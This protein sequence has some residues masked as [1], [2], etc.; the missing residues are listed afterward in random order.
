[1]NDSNESEDSYLKTGLKYAGM[2]LG[3]VV[4]TSVVA[5]N[6]IANS[7]TDLRIKKDSLLSNIQKQEIL[8]SNIKKQEM[9]KKS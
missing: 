9:F 5:T 6:A 2:F 7:F 3:G 8:K 1:M 4:V